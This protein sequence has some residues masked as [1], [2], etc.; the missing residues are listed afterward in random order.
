VD[1]E[2]STIYDGGYLIDF[3]SVRLIVS[4]LNNAQ[5]TS[6]IAVLSSINSQSLRILVSMSVRGVGVAEYASVQDI[7]THYD[8]YTFSISGGELQ[9]FG[10]FETCLTEL[11]EQTFLSYEKA[12]KVGRCTVCE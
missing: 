2:G 6:R 11:A 1:V 3:N 9:H 7:K 10:E 5:A 4:M 12:A 8:D